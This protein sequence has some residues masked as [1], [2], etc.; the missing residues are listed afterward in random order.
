MRSLLLLIP[1]TALA[2]GGCVVGTASGKPYS[3]S[4]RHAYTAVDRVD[5]AAAVEVVVAQGAFDVKA[6]TTDGNDFD[7]LI[8]EVRSDTLHIGRKP[9]M[10]NWGGPHYRVTVSAPAYSGF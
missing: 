10:W 6:Q 3:E 8:V 5:A 1:L 7:N 9:Q 4:Q 2:A